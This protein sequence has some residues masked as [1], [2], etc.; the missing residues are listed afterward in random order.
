[1]LSTKNVDKEAS[2]FSS[3]D[4]RNDCQKKTENTEST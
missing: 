1:M 2:E 3:F 4:K